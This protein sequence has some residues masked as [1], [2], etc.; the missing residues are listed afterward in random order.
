M[1]F[2]D[3]SGDIVVDAVLTDTGRMRLAKGDGQ[4]RIYMFALC[5]DEIDYSLYDLSK[6]T[7]QRDVELLKTPILEAVTDNSASMLSKLLTIN[8]ADLLYLP[9]MKINTLLTPMYTS[10]SISNVYIVCVDGATSVEFA[11][12]SNNNRVNGVL[13]GKTGLSGPVLIIDQGLDTTEISADVVLDPTLIETSYRVE[14]NSLYGSIASPGSQQIEISP[15]YVD[16]D[17]IASYVFSY[18]TI[19]P[20]NNVFVVRNNADSTATDQVIAGPR[21]TRL[22]FRIKASVDLATS[23][24][25]FLTHGGETTMVG[26]SGVKNVRY[27]DTYIRIIGVNTGYSID[28]PLRFVRL[29]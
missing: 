5:D 9:V 16:D 1:A 12:D 20:N 25:L 4:F 18:N 15:S 24:Y 17:F 23:D 14:M 11:K 8:R 21:G 10:T 7:D 19:N 13:E 29:K 3:S 6:P 26:K 2:L 22:R 28:V 27:I